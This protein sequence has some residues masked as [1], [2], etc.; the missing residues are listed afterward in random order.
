MADARIDPRPLQTSRSTA[1][2]AQV[3]WPLDYMGRAVSRSAYTQTCSVKCLCLFWIHGAIQV[4]L[5]YGNEPCPIKYKCQTSQKST[6]QP[7]H[8]VSCVIHDS[9]T[10][11]IKEETRHDRVEHRRICGFILK[12]EIRSVE[13]GICPIAESLSCSSTQISWRG[14]SGD[15]RTFKGPSS[16]PG[17][18]Y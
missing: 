12:L 9:D 14:N 10:W 6:S 18:R 4:T 1:H 17:G 13:R 8:Y 7:K 11:W 3:V 5:L 2:G 15:S 16:S